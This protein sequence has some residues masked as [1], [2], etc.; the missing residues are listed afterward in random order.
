MASGFYSSSTVGICTG[1]NINI[2]AKFRKNSDKFDVPVK[3]L[4]ADLTTELDLARNL[5]ES[6]I[7][8]DGREPSFWPPTS[9]SRTTGAWH[10]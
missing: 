10:R 4:K 8:G 9:T 2:A 5:A 3:E 1:G 6:E 7:T